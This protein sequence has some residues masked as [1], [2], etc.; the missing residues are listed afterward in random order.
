MD[1]EMQDWEAAA[2]PVLCYCCDCVLQPLR[3]VWYD[4]DD[5]NNDEDEESTGFSSCIWIVVRNTGSVYLLWAPLA[6]V[7]NV[8]ENED[9]VGPE[10]PQRG[11][12]GSLHLPFPAR[13]DTELS[14]TSSLFLCVCLSTSDGRMM[15]GWMKMPAPQNKPFTSSVC[16]TSVLLLLPGGAYPTAPW[17]APP[18]SPLRRGR[19]R[20]SARRTWGWSGSRWDTR[21]RR[22]RRRPR[23]SAPRPPAMW[24]WVSAFLGYSAAEMPWSG[25][26]VPM[27]RSVRHLPNLLHTR[28]RTWT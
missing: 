23:R 16:R 24:H 28:T 22:R 4:D 10:E 27:E 14:V 11:L 20:S 18:P 9:N 26:L 2:A 7:E 15:D 21:R 25:A 1:A 6:F 8:P 12:E 5:D 19:C 3:P 13:L 17:L